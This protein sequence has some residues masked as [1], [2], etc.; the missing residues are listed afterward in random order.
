MTGI[1]IINSESEMYSCE[2]FLGLNEPF[3][4]RELRYNRDMRQVE[5][6]SEFC[7]IR[8]AAYRSGLA[9]KTWYQGGAGTD[10][11]P[12]VRFGRSVRLLRSDVERF[13]ND[14]LTDAKCPVQRDNNK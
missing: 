3:E 7:T 4:Q 2:E 14:R 5:E 6:N 12:R 11:V 9:L 13:I 8:Y 10:V 1:R